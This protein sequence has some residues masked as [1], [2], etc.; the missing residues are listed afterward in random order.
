MGGTEFLS[1]VDAIIH[2]ATPLPGKASPEV[3]LAVGCP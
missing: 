1:G 2:V 3:A